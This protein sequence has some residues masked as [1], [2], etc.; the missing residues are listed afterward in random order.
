MAKRTAKYVSAEAVGLR[1]NL[2]WTMA[3][4]LYAAIEAAGYMWNSEL[5]RWQDLA[6]IPALAASKQVLVRV[7]TD[8]DKVGGVAQHLIERMMPDYEL[9]N[10]TSKIYPCRPPQHNDGR[11]YMAFIPGGSL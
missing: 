9:L 5:G 7:W 1:L 11:I 6:A 2:N 4:E 3:D 8:K 10:P